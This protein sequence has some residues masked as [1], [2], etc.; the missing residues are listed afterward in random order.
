MNKLFKYFLT[1]R[2][3]LKILL[4]IAIVAYFVIELWLKRYEELFDGGY[5]I[6]QFFSMLSISYI[7]AFI[8]YFIVVHIKSRHHILGGWS[9]PI[10]SETGKKRVV[11]R[12]F[13]S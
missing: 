12:G 10:P 4:L 2:K 5:E 13:Y 8:F 7:S 1:T 11:L 3:D 9:R 6:G